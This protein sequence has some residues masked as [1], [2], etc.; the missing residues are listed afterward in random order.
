MAEADKVDAAF[1]ERADKFIDLA[2][3]QCQDVGQGKVSA[4]FMYALT[5]FNAWVSACGCDDSQQMQG[6][7]QEAID[8]F[9]EQFKSMLE[10]N[11]DDYIANYAKYM[12]SS[13]S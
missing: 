10:E 5:R 3:A 9:M 11:I 1:F 2:N 8:Y 13:Q 6:A 12:R 7:R 4:S